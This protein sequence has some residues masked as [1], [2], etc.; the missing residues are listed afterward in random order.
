MAIK[1]VA[2]VLN[3][4]AGALLDQ[5]EAGGMLERALADAGLEAT[6]IPQDAGSLPERIQ[7]AAESGADAVVVA[8]G[9]GTVA[10]R[11]R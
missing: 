4:K 9:A 11:R 5:E 3:G 1:R 10:C 6:F 8:G 2:V 7:Q